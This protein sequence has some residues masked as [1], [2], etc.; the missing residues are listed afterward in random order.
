MTRAAL[1]MA[2]ALVLAGCSGTKLSPQ[3][4]ASVIR[5]D[6]R[7]REPGLVS[8]PRKDA[9]TVCKA[10]LEADA[11]WRALAKAGW[12]EPRDDDDFLRAIEGRPEQKCVGVL[13]GDGLRAGATVDT[14]T[15]TLWRVPAATR[16]LVSIQSV[17]SSS[18]GISTIAFTF[19]WRPNVFGREILQPGPEIPGVAI[20]RLVVDEWQVVDYTALPDLQ[21]PAVLG[22]LP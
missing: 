6:A 13:T 15:F 3:T 17:S 22:P 5:E 16:E 11:G 20:L 19:R 7:F 1:L 9:G 18:H 12:M 2:A 8:V 4:A 10:K 14:T 21:Q